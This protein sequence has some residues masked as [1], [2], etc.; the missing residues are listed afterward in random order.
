M[1]TS[2]ASIRK[3]KIIMENRCRRRESREEFKVFANHIVIIRV[4]QPPRNT[5]MLYIYYMYNIF[6]YY[7]YKVYEPPYNNWLL[8]FDSLYIYININI[9]QYSYKL[10]KNR[11]Q[12]TTDNTTNSRCII[13]WVVA[14]LAAEKI[15][16]RGCCKPFLLSK[17][18]L[19]YFKNLLTFLKIFIHFTWF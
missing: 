15:R 13:V 18:T 1:R 8:R 10:A 6:I 17:R 14:N 19:Q 9:T 4:M 16:Y 7:Y 5:I 2:V 3:S 12:N 11:K